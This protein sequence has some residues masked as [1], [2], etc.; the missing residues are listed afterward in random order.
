[1]P[2]TLPICECVSNVALVIVGLRTTAP[3]IVPVEAPDD[4]CVSALGDGFGFGDA[5]E[6]LRMIGSL[7][8]LICQLLLPSL[9]LLFGS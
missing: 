8:D 7:D 9:I 2:R 1:M 3:A 4:D 5:V 6:L